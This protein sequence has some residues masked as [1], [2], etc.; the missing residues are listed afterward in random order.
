MTWVDGGTNYDELNSD[1]FWSVYS[2]SK[3]RGRTWSDK[4]RLAIPFPQELAYQ[5]IP[6][7]AGSVIFPQEPPRGL[8]DGAV[9]MSGFWRNSTDGHYASD[10]VLFFR[11]TD[12]GKTWSMSPVDAFEWERNESSWV[13]LGG[14]KVLMVLRSNYTNSVGQSISHDYGRT[15]SRVTP[16]GIPYFGPSAPSILRTR[17]GVLVLAVRGWGVFTSVDD[18]LT[19][20]HPTHVGGY[21]GEGMAGNMFEMSDG[22]IFTMASDHGN[23]GDLCRMYAQFIRVTPDGMVHPAP[24][25]IPH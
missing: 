22:R 15:W 1:N 5:R 10:Q 19:W 9:A 16:L 7:K 17:E 8:S 2:I 11:S 18:G 21:V 3:D 24:I 13:E 12:E 4:Q 20:N 6:G 23:A 14:G 25:G